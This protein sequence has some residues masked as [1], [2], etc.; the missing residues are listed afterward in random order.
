MAKTKRTK[1]TKKSV[2]KETK[3]ADESR[4]PYEVWF[5]KKLLEKKVNKWQEVE[6]RVFFKSKGLSNL[7]EIEIYNKYFELY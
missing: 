5:S 2:V 7:E 6:L 3:K 4:V 1:K